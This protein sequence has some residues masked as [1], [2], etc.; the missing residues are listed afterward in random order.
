MTANSGPSTSVRNDDRQLL[1][2]RVITSRHFSKSARLRDL[3]LYVS[4]RVLREGATE[5]HEQ[6]VGHHVFG[7]EPDYD[8]ASDNTVRVHGLD[9]AKA[10]GALL[11][12]GR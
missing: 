4:E 9:S 5:V 1:V 8:T 2:E 10:S 6:E 12:D 3:L 11:R 7:R